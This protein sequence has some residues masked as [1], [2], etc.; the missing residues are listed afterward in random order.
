MNNERIV[1][2]L[3]AILFDISFPTLYFNCVSLQF[4]V[5]HV[6][7]NDFPT[8][9]SHF[10]WILESVLSPFDLFDSLYLFIYLFI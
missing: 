4:L 10:L 5:T 3:S 9:V 8:T 6:G 2:S 1:I 7:K